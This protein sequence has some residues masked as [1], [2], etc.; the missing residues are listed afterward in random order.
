[1]TDWQDDEDTPRRSPIRCRRCGN[2]ITRDQQR[3][4]FGRA[5]QT[6]GLT[7]DEAKR[8]MPRCQKCL[9]EMF[10]PERKRRP[11]KP[12]RAMGGTAE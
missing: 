4:Q 3:R 2:P 7:P 1:M 6:Y 9:T 5:I 11:P 8:L 12:L 10:N